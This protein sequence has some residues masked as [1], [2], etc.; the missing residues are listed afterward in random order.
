M[1]TAALLALLVAA[2]RPPT[3][4]TPPAAPEPAAPSAAGHADAKRLGDWP[5]KE[6]G[7]VVTI[8][9][10][11]SIDDALERIAAAAGWNL[12]ANTGRLGDRTLI[13]TFHETPVE[14]ALDAV[15]E[16]SPLVATRR[17]NT[18]TVSPGRAPPPPQ[19]TPTLSG[20]D[21]PSGKRFSGDFT[22]TPIAD[23]LR[24]VSDAAGLSIVLP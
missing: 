11:V 5:R 20:F 10:H 16:G 19:E 2:P 18:V 9:E 15:L 1:V 3:P 6:S 22:D 14:E 12:V 7:K 23:A 13:V 24:K 4:P 8:G 21:K 17:G